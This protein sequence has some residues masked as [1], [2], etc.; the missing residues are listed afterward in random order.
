MD[1][2]EATVC[3]HGKK[4]SEYCFDCV[5][6]RH[7]ED[8]ADGM[9]DYEDQERSNASSETLRAAQGDGVAGLPLCPVH[10]AIDARGSLEVAISG[11]NCV[12]CSL[13]ERQELLDLLAPFAPEDASEDSVTVL[14]KLAEFYDT[15][16]GE[17]RVVVSYPTPSPLPEG[18]MYEDQL[19][20][21]M[22]QADYD[23]W[24]K[25]SFVDGVRVGP[26]Y[27]SPSS[28]PEGREQL[29]LSALLAIDISS[30]DAIAYQLE[31]GK[32]NGDLSREV[33][34]VTLRRFANTF[35]LAN[36]RATAPVV[37]TLFEAKL[38]GF[39]DKWRITLC[40]PCLMRAIDEQFVISSSAI[41][42]APVEEKQNEQS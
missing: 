33:L 42:T 39:D 3:E 32:D 41:P 16:V 18:L 26:K 5:R 9:F 15:H 6:K 19:P 40:Q 7:S 24:Y 8:M 20:A 31:Q 13:N 1:V 28:L 35:R 36:T 22:P 38:L 27:P 11:N 23:T 17:S 2:N 12:A 34:A 21:D 10:A 25:E 14:R 30:A 29:P 37:E 4:P